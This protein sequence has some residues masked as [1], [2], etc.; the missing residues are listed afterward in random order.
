MQKKASKRCQLQGVLCPVEDS[1]ATVLNTVA[2]FRHLKTVYSKKMFLV[3]K[4]SLFLLILSVTCVQANGIG[5][6]V[7]YSGKNVP[8]KKVLT[9]IKRQ[10]GYVF[11]YNKEDIKN[12]NPVSVSVENM[13]VNT[14]IDLVLQN[15]PVL[16]KLMGQTIILSEKSAVKEMPVN[17][18]IVDDVIITGK[19]V[20]AEGTPIPNA[21]AI[22]KG[23]RKATSAGANG[24]FLLKEIS[25]KRTVLE[26]SAVGFATISIEIV[27][28]KPTR[29]I[30][31]GNDASENVDKGSFTLL[32][33]GTLLFTLSRSVNSLDQVVVVGYGTQMRRNVTGSVSKVDMKETEELPNTNITEALRGRVAGVQVISGNRPGQNGTIL[34]RGQRSLSASNNPL[35]VLDGIMFN[36]NLTDINP[37]DILS[38]EILKDASATAIYGSRAANGVILIT[39]KRGNTTK[40]LIN[41]NSYYGFTDYSYKLKTLS[42]DRYIQ[43]IIDY[44]AEIGN[45]VDRTNVADYLPANVAENFKANKSFDPWKIASQ[46]ASIASLDVSLSGKTEKTN[47]YFSASKVKENGLILNDQ[48][49]RLTLRSNFESNV[50]TWATLGVNSTFISRDNSGAVASV[51]RITRTVPY[52]TLYDEEGIPLQYPVDGEGAA[53][54]PLY[55]PYLSSN[56]SIAENLFANFY[57]TLN[58]PF[59][60]GLSYRLNFSPNLRW[61]NQSDFRRRDQRLESN[62]TSASKLNVKSYDWM[63]ENILNYKKQFKDHGVDLT[64]LYGRNHTGFERQGSNAQLLASEALGWYDLSLGE[65]QTVSSYAERTDGVSSMARLNYNYKNKYFLTLTTRRDGSSVFSASNK[66][67]VFPSASAAWLLSEE[68]FLDQV[69]F[70]DYLK[71]RVSY[72]AVGNQ[73]ISPYQSLSLLGINRYVFGDGGSSVLGVFPNN[74]SN[75]QLKWETT[76]TTNIGLDFEIFRGRLGGTFEYYNMNTEDLLVKRSIPI[77][78]GFN[79]IWSNLGATNNRG[80]E[81]SLNTVNVRTKNFTWT[82]NLNFSRNVN[83][84]VHLYHSDVDGDGI[85]DDDISNNWFIGQPI[86]VFYDFAFDGIYQEKDQLPDGVKPGAVRLKDKNGNGVIDAEDREIIGQGQ[87][88]YRWGITNTFKYRQLSLSVFV[89]AM[90]GWISTTPRWVSIGRSLNF[91]D[92]GWWTPENMSNEMPSITYQNR[93]GHRYYSS[94]DFIRIQDV[95]LSYEFKKEFI[96]RIGLSGLRLYASGKNIYTFTKWKGPDPENGAT[97]AADYYPVPRTISFG[98]NASF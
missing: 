71:L 91:I 19:I 70:L 30:D 34:I 29:M 93:Y 38:M 9:E 49:D 54:N 85:E 40:P 26:I 56:Q 76:Y 59:I 10:T 86:D 47:Y 75:S 84:I 52:G 92:V 51:E 89:N 5:Q 20:D 6:L 50:A 41:V 33:D 13:P 67:A 87:P 8:L 32:D 61:T 64:L 53:E 73:A 55:V 14:F 22:I 35:I 90:Q 97:N 96:N 72:G 23:T 95:T 74:M 16:Y 37:N 15:Q 12:A 31:A 25:Q 69:N 58:A 27:N 28:G 18:P 66:Y 83:K 24:I 57:V 78:T 62:L 2:R 88:K 65:V 4:L 3:M 79:D 44:N 45:D 17:N 7:S 21:S 80:V 81:L 82:T 42:P 11:F 77:M 46:D 98:L 48:Q 63:L 1:N 94:R 43:Y 60:K 68:N 36:G 39:S